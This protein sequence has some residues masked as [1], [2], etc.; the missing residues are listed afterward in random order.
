MAQAFTVLEVRASEEPK[1]L[2]VTPGQLQ[3][4]P[5]GEGCAQ[6]GPLFNIT[7]TKSSKDLTF[8]LRSPGKDELLATGKLTGSNG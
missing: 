7:R 6:D 2:Y 4:G 1:H 8:A 5:S 3:A